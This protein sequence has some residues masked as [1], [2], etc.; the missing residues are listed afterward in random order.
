MKVGAT[1]LSEL[2]VLSDNSRIIKTND[3]I[4]STPP[5]CEKQK[6]PIG[7]QMTAAETAIKNELEE[8]DKVKFDLNQIQLPGPLA[9]RSE[10]S[11]LEIACNLTLPNA[12]HEKAILKFDGGFCLELDRSLFKRFET[13][14][15]KD[16]PS[17]ENKP[18]IRTTIVH[19]DK[20]DPFK[21]KRKK[22]VKKKF[23]KKIKPPAPDGPLTASQLMDVVIPKKLNFLKSPPPNL[24]EKGPKK[25]NFILPKL[26]PECS[27]TMKQPSEGDAKTAS[28]EQVTTIAP[29][30]GENPQFILQPMFTLSYPPLPNES[31]PAPLPTPPAASV[32][33]N[34]VSLHLSEPSTSYTTSTVFG[35]ATMAENSS[36]VCHK[37]PLIVTQRPSSYTSSRQISPRK[38]HIQQDQNIS[39]SG[40][41]SSNQSSV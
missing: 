3:V 13:R 41:G 26:G 12:K 32:L 15:K 19:K 40:Y 6:H 31:S 10:R 5:D 38:E 18:K 2:K 11:G 28:Q 20:S 22:I 39:L 21:F 9:N 1:E 36:A 34:V 25:M 24:T 14:V 37:L 35:Q 29:N 4:V 7:Q 27:V 16:M 23:A 33:S 17:V 30:T 8:E